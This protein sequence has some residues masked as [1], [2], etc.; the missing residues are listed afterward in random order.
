METKILSLPNLPRN[1]KHRSRGKAAR[2]QVPHLPQA[3]KSLR[4][5]LAAPGSRQPNTI[6]DQ[7]ETPPELALF[8]TF[9]QF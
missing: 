5:R 6:A 1:R 9:G 7:L 8:T 4:G 3:P 2:L